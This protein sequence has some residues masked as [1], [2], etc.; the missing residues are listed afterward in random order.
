MKSYRWLFWLLAATGLIV[1]QATKYGIFSHLY[2]DGAGGEITLIE[3]CL[4]IE[5]QFEFKLHG[6]WTA[7]KEV[8]NPVILTF[9]S[10]SI[11]LNVGKEMREGTYAADWRKAELDVDWGDGELARLGVLRGSDGTLIL[12][13]VEPGKGPL[14]FARDKDTL[15]RKL[16]TISG[17]EL[18]RVNEGALFGLGRGYNWVF[19]VVSIGAALLIVIFSGRSAIRRDL[20][21]SIALGLILAGTL[22]N[23]Y[24]RLVFYGVRDFIH[25]FGLFDWPVFNIADC[26]LVV[27]AGTLLVHAFFSTDAPAQP[28]AA[29]EQESAAVPT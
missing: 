12:D 22:G 21:L 4:A 9:G 17:E 27:G 11:T 15:L 16:Q 1:D 28:V 20:F 5:A 14:T 3:N 7:V 2:H 18:P 13:N 26:C 29:K 24:D 19:G 6:S 8:S 23:F 25:W 10:K